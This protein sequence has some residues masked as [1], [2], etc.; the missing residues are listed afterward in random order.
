MISALLGVPPSRTSSVASSH[1][2]YEG[3]MTICMR[4]TRRSRSRT[5][6]D[7]HESHGSHELGDMTP[8]LPLRGFASCF[9]NLLRLCH[10]TILPHLLC[11]LRHHL[12]HL[13]QRLRNP[14]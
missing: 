11:Q 8:R 14:C 2:R 5:T 12:S 7:V 4:L 10:P 9:L 3:E 13:Y 1:R 6:A